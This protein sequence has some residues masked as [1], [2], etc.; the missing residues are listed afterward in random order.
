MFYKLIRTRGISGHI[1]GFRHLPS[2]P[3]RCQAPARPALDSSSSTSPLLHLV[4]LFCTS[5]NPPHS[6]TRSVSLDSSLLTQTAPY[7]ATSALSLRSNACAPTLLDIHDVFDVHGKVHPLLY[8][9]LLIS[10]VAA[11]YI[12]ARG[13]CK[14]AFP[15]AHILYWASCEQGR[16]SARVPSLSSSFT[17]SIC[18][19]PAPHL[20]EAIGTSCI[21]H[22]RIIIVFRGCF[23]SHQERNC[24]YSSVQRNAIC[25]LPPSLHCGRHAVGIFLQ[26]SGSTCLIV[27]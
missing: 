7:E 2:R 15:V 21:S 13:Y 17:S 20:P 1:A 27:G 6:F 24:T 12:F 11:L 23:L 4:S 3:G 19:F 16:A 8:I 22:L 9:S 25:L 10:H 26:G 14:A 5:R 18:T